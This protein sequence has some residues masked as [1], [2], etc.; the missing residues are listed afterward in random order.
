MITVRTIVR[1]PPISNVTAIY[2]CSPWGHI[3]RAG[4]GG[5][6]EESCSPCHSITDVRG[7]DTIHNTIKPHAMTQKTDCV[8]MALMMDLVTL[9]LL[10][11]AIGNV[12]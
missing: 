10:T 4:V 7:S 6:I 3:L 12:P 2:S 11:L 9:I 8:M 1:T 5:P